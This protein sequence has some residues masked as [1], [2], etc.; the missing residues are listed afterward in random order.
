MFDYKYIIIGTIIVL[1]ILILIDLFII[2]P[3]KNKKTY[4]KKECLMTN[5][6]LKY[7]NALRGILSKTPYILIPQMPLSGIVI[8]KE[9]HSFQS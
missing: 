5:T 7:F 2:N 6:E 4:V 9:P 1:T 8:R 3:N